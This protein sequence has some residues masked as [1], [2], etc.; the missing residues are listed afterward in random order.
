MALIMDGKSGAYEQLLFILMGRRGSGHG[1]PA[2]RF[3]DLASGLLQ[4][5]TYYHLA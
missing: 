4:N 1:D 5:S 3:N 2:Q